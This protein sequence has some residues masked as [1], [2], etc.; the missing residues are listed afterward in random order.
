[1]FY[2]WMDGWIHSVPATSNFLLGKINEIKISVTFKIFQDVFQ[3]NETVS[4]I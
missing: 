2:D 3:Y 1:M 4:A